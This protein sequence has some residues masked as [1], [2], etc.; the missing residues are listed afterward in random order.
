MLDSITPESVSICT[1]PYSKTLKSVFNM[2]QDLK[3]NETAVP[4]KSFYFKTISRI[5]LIFFIGF[6]VFL[7][8]A[9]LILIFLTKPEG[10]VEVPNVIGK[11]YIEINNTLI[12]K[13]FRPSISFRDVYEIE[14]GIV[15]E[16][17]PDPG[18]IVSTGSKIRLFVS[19]SNL[20]VEVP[21]ISGLELPFALNK[22]KNQHIQERSIS[23]PVGVIS[24]MPS[25]TIAEN[26]VIDQSPK[27]GEK[28]TLER[29]VNLLVS[30]GKTDDKMEMPDLTGQSIELGFSL[31]AAKGTYVRQNIVNA[32]DVELSGLISSQTPLKGSKINKGDTITLTVNYYKMNEHPY[33]AY[34]LIS[35][36]IPKDEK[37]GV[38]EAFVEDSVSKR[39]SFLAPM[40]PG[41]TMSFVFH[42]TG[43]AR[44]NILSEKRSIKVFKFNVE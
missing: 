16:Q 25:D 36:T 7:F 27:P 6:S 30:S 44:V 4:G 8:F 15:L 35:Y 37:A 9:T 43:N 14:N 33:R 22:L 12:R 38:Y 10:E 40:S 28:I 24:Y 5:S 41:Q 2:N 23:L 17:H 26:V 3:T 18:S 32:L 39:L 19:R 21:D 42:R 1:N 13:E 34:E 11:R 29:K 31:L 20:F